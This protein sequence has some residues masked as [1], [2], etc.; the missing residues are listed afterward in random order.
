MIRVVKANMKMIPLDAKPQQ[1]I[2]NTRTGY[3]KV[4]AM[5]QD[6]VWEQCDATVDLKNLLKGNAFGF[7]SLLRDH[8]E[9]VRY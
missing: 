3:F 1:A 8:S 6:L 4:G 2:T 9:D 7:S 5:T